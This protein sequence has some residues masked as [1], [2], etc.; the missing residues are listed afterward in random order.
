MCGKSYCVFIC[1]TV[2]FLCTALHVRAETLQEIVQTTLEKNPT[3]IGAQAGKSAAI[4]EKKQEQANYYPDISTNVTGG[5]VLQDNSTSR[6]FNTTRDR[7]ASGYGEANV[8]FRQ[9]VFDGFETQNRV[10]AAQARIQS[11]DYIVL[12]TQEQVV[13]NITRSYIDILRV[14]YALARLSEQMDRIKDYQSRI[15]KLV[16]EGVADETELQQ[17]RDVE[18]IVHGVIAQYEGEMSA[19]QAYYYE[20]TGSA[21]PETMEIPPSMEKYLQGDRDELIKRAKA[22]HPSVKSAAMESKAADYDA[23]AQEGV[24]YPDLISELSYLK[25]DKRD[26]IG[27]ENEDARAV[28]RM[29][30]NFSL[31][32]RGNAS[33][34]Q[35]QYEHAK[36]KARIEETQRQIERDIRQSF[37][38]YTMLKKQYELSQARVDLNK[39]LLASY[40]VQ[41]EGSRVSLLNLLRAESQLFNALLEES[42]NQFNLLAS[43]YGVL[44]SL[45]RIKKAI[46]SPT[47]GEKSE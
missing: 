17:A 34:K 13:L 38:T 4:Y 25:S 41:F 18:M 6:G 23:K 10:S 30:W 7:A 3:I 9:P 12:D 42:D 16:K 26:E 8:T 20:I 36:T 43:E 46:I 22:A 5:R 44:A 33:I 40:K 21:P 11:L 31:G 27:G 1:T 45:G 14:N 28:M 2:L 47:K 32:E 39:D 24:L 15:A 35:K 19:A 37:A 29:N